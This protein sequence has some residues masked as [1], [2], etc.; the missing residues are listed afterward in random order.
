MEIL[1]PRIDQIDQSRRH[2]HCPPGEGAPHRIRHGQED[3]RFGEASAAAGIEAG[4][5]AIWNRSTRNWRRSQGQKKPKAR[6]L[7]ILAALERVPCLRQ[8]VPC[9]KNRPPVGAFWAD[10]VSRACCRSSVVEHSIGN[11]EVDSS[12]LSGS[13]IQRADYLTFFMFDFFAF[14]RKIGM[15]PPRNPRELCGG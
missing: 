1:W 11:G 8:T 9:G 7:P 10:S 6:F 4:T 14:Q 15:E 12:I 2:V 3:G 13:T 5:P